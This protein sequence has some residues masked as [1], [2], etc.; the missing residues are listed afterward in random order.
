MA[1][2][3][4]NN[5]YSSD[6]EQCGCN[7]IFSWRF[8]Y[9]LFEGQPGISYELW[10]FLFLC[11]FALIVIAALFRTVSFARQK[12]LSQWK[13]ITHLLVLMSALRMFDFP[14]LLFLFAHFILVRVLY[15]ATDPTGQEGMSVMFIG[16][17][18]GLGNYFLF[19]AYLAT[20][21]N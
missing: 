17:V 5:N 12:L 11:F 16:L 10:R 18:F 21:L 13:G 9:P 1:C 4:A 19:M 20:G 8:I 14:S 3:G 6:D 15:F 2:T 7:S